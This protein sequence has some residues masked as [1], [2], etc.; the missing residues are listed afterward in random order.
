M[1]FLCHVMCS[2]LTWD[3]QTEDR[4]KDKHW[5]VINVTL[6]PFLSYD[7][8]LPF[9]TNDCFC[10][11]EYVVMWFGLKFW[12]YSR[13]E[14]TRRLNIT[15]RSSKS[16][17]LMSRF[18]IHEGVISSMIFCSWVD[19]VYWEPAQIVGWQVAPEPPTLLSLII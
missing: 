14:S 1:S 12:K 9:S 16:I 4:I 15:D 13:H 6:L 3:F 19:W 18:I 2:L 10:F 17:K 11:V 5:W 7:S 8:Y